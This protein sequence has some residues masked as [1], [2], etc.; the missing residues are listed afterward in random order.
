M[1]TFLRRINQRGLGLFEVLVCVS[2]L[3]A[4]LVAIFQPLLASSI[5]LENAE[6]RMAGYHRMNERLWEVSEKLA[7]KKGIG[8]PKETEILTHGNRVYRFSV[9]HHAVSG[10]NQLRQLTGSISWQSSGRRNSL[11]RVIYVTQS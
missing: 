1:K 11:Q 5:A 7:R 4:G 2:I 10:F 9:R 3:S 6:Y 8:T